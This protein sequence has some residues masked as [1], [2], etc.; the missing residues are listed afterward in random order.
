ML[1]FIINYV[2]LIYPNIFSLG[3]TLFLMVEL[4]IYC[5]LTTFF[6]GHGTRL[7]GIPVGL[8]SIY[9][10]K[11]N[12]IEGARLLFIFLL[13]AFIICFY[14]IIHRYYGVNKNLCR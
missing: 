12:N 14:D 7:I 1:Y 11:N 5:T 8:Y 3:S 2:L 6:M 4:Y 9:S 13:F 10:I